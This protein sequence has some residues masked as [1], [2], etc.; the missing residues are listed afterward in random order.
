MTLA[1]P[2]FAPEAVADAG[3]GR[4]IVLIAPFVDRRPQVM[5]CG[6]KKNAY[7]WDTA[8]V[9]CGTP[10]DLLIAQLLE[11]ELQAWGFRVLVNPPEEALAA[12]PPVLII[13]GELVQYFV[14]PVVEVF[15]VSPEA[16]IE[17][18]LTA[19]SPAGLVAVR[20]FYVKGT[21][22]SFSGADYNIQYAHDTA[23]REVVLSLGKSIV[24][25]ANRYPMPAGGV[26]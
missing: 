7:G 9:Y 26:S 18:R 19:T 22:T 24:S 21:E 12:E 25:L 2:R 4:T 8:D 17:V 6:M 13:R 10:P 3:H 16:D 5:R 20:N 14:E 15:T 23:L 11:Q 1:A